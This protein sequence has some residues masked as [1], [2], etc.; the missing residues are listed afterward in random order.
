MP[1]P[2]RHISE[3]PEDYLLT[4]LADPKLAAQQ[5]A[6][7]QLLIA[8]FHDRKLD[9]EKLRKALDAGA[10]PSRVV[11]NGYPALHLAVMRRS[12]PAVAL[13][14]QHGAIA[15]D[16]DARGVTALKEAI[17][18]DFASAIKLIKQ[19]GGEQT[20]PIFE[21]NYQIL[22]D[23]EMT[24][25]AKYGKVDQ[26]KSAILLGADVNAKAMPPLLMAMPRCDA[27]IVDV[28]LKAGADPGVQHSKYGNVF[29][30]IWRASNSVLGSRQWLDFY[31]AVTRLC[32]GHAGS[33]PNPNMMTVADLLQICPVAQQKDC[34]YLHYLIEAGKADFVMDVIRRDSKNRL[35]AE[36]FLR[37][38]GGHTLLE[39]IANKGYLAAF[40]SP[41][42]WQG[43][44]QEMLSLENHVPSMARKCFDFNQAAAKLRAVRFSERRENARRKDFNTNP[45]FPGK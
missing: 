22:I 30:Q 2:P 20:A 24:N 25:V 33:A 16:V 32:P 36:D 3:S 17:N 31:D 27:D 15:S 45:F 39:V 9:I 29:T 41:D 40:L 21:S 34:T 19:Y 14:L 7:D 4:V 28:L 23:E 18:I 38:T 13:L 26:L 6:A 10:N 8:A 1:Y 12:S 44:V 37:R 43:R 5:A 35:T 42:V 11:W